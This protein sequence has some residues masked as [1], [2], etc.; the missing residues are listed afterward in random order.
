MGRERTREG[1]FIYFCSASLIFFILSGCMPSKKVLTSSSH[2]EISPAKIQ[3]QEEPAKPDCEG[4]LATPQHVGSGD[5]PDFRRESQRFSSL[6][7]RGS[8]KERALF[9]LGL[10]YA[11]VDNPQR[12]FKKALELFRKILKDYPQSPLAEEA[13]ILSGVLQENEKLSQ[14]IEQFKQVDID[15][16]EKKREKAR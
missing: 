15:V 11:R 9:N 14:V 8:P 3:K 12:D 16:E 5:S 10:N 13:R 6:S 7:G 2:Q 4:F 1:K